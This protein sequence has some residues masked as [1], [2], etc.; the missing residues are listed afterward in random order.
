MVARAVT[1]HE[2]EGSGWELLRAKTV[3]HQWLSHRL[4]SRAGTPGGVGHRREPKLYMKH[5]D[6]V[7]IEVEGV[8]TLR[9]PVVKEAAE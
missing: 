8:G 2:T 7:E 3:I 9:N 6:I 1:R 4:V 5:G